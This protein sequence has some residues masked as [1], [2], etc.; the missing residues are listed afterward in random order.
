MKLLNLARLL[1]LAP[2]VNSIPQISPRQNCENTA[3]NRQCWGEYGVDTDFY[4]VVPETG[5]TREVRRYIY[6]YI[7]II[8][9]TREC[10]PLL[11]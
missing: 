5:V 6:I 8:E 1:A 4:E 2:V 11:T 9:T 7:Y 3:T 10:Y